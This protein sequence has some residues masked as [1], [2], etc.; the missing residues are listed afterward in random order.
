MKVKVKGSI[1]DLLAFKGLVPKRRK[2][3]LKSP[4][5]PLVADAVGE[6]SRV[7]HPRVRASPYSGPTIRSS[8]SSWTTIPGTSSLWDGLYGR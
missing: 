5:T 3:I 7:L 4:D 8:S 1:R 6:L 2:R